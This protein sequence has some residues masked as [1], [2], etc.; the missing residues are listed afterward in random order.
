MHASMRKT[1][2]HLTRPGAQAPKRA[3]ALQDQAALR[4]SLF[5]C[6]ACAGNLKL[7]ARLQRLRKVF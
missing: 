5:R 4:A 1:Q 3:Y 6:A 7:R 2:L